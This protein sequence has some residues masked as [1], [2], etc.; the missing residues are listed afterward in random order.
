MENKMIEQK[1]DEL[2]ELYA[3]RDLSEMEKKRLIDEV[4]TAEIKAKIAEI[5]AEF[6]G[7]G[8]S[9]S[10]KIAE[11]EAEVKE[12]V[13]TAGASVKGQFLHAVFTKGRVTWDSKALDGY[14]KAHPELAEYRKEGEPSVS[15]RKV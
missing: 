3:Q 10:E 11:L 6:L 4:M 9:V 15:L 1:L 2:A 13:K 14:A 12:A 7:R 5:E 8:E